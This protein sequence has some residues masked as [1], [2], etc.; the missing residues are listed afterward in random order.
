MK[1]VTALVSCAA[2]LAVGLAGCGTETPESDPQSQT[3]SESP[4]A[5]A[6]AQLTYD[7]PDGFTAVSNAQVE[8]P[9]TENYEASALQLDDASAN[10]MIYVVSYLLEP[11]VLTETRNQQE[12]VVAEYDDVLGNLDEGAVNL[13]LVGGDQ[14]LFRRAL[15]S[16]SSGKRVYQ[17]NTF[18]FNGLQLIQVTC[19]WE[20]K[21][22]TP[23][24]RTAMYEGCQAVQQSLEI[25]G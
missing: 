16:N 1:R 19:Q 12:A 24:Q 8:F 6:P 20:E 9:V 22:S 3:S 17:D 18:L 25:T 23:E 4:A 14:G 15:F 2:V 7:A 5:T 10:Y 11:G 13:A 21:D